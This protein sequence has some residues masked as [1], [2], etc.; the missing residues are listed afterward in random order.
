M[1]MLTS[2]DLYSNQISDVTPLAGMA[3]LERLYLSSNASQISRRW[4]V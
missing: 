4:R 2:L 3:D 1:T